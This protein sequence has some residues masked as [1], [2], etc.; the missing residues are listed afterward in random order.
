MDMEYLLWLQN[1]RNSIN[2]ALTPFMEWVSHF[3]VNWLILIPAFVYWVVSKRKGL[4]TLTSAFVCIAVN[5]LIKL[6]ACVY[7]PWIR[8]ERILPA[9]DAIREST[10]Y[11][12]PSGHTATAAPIAGGLAVG[13]WKKYKWI[14]ALCVLFALIVGFS[15]NYLGVHTPQDV[16]VA[17]ALSVASL[18]AVAWVMR[19]LEQHPDKE[20]T[21]LFAMFIV[22]CAGVAYVTFKPYPMDYK[23][24]LG[25]LLVDPQ[26]MMNDGYSD[27]SQLVVFPVARYTERRFIGFR[28]TGLTRAGVVTGVIGLIPLWAMI[29]WLGAPLDQMLGKHWGHFLN[30]S[31]IVLYI[32]ALYP[33][34]I[35]LTERPKDAETV[36]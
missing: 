7:R 11:S 16:A 35:R 15:R 27:Q 28:E 18:F 17:A 25:E 9:G 1:F 2:D 12:F 8:D 3:S 31:I 19:Y 20:D 30:S 14:S 29:N 22:G 33:I 23:G 13:A 32:V 6:T 4:Y 21:F 36:E 10:G 24:P 5:Q 26:R 34:V